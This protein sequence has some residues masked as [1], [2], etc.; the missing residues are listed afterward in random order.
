MKKYVV[1]Q[2]I[3]TWKR[4]NGKTIID[5]TVQDEVFVKDSDNWAELWNAYSGEAGKTQYDE[6]GIWR[7]YRVY[8]KRA[9]ARRSLKAYAIKNGRG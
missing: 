8:Y 6:C 4:E 5:C 3:G 9:E 1:T 7:C 2:E